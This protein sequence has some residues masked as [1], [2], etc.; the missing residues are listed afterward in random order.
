MSG[1]SRLLLQVGR[2][3]GLRRGQARGDGIVGRHA[4][5]VICA[6]DQ[7]SCGRKL[8]AFL[9]VVRSSLDFLMRSRTSRGQDA[10]QLGRRSAAS[11]RATG[12]GA[13]LRFP[14]VPRRPK[15]NPMPPP[16]DPDLSVRSAR[17]ELFAQM[18]AGS[19]IETILPCPIRPRREQH[20][21]RAFSRNQW[22]STPRSSDQNDPRG[23]ILLGGSGTQAGGLNPPCCQSWQPSI[24]HPRSRPLRP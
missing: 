22:C 17:P 2:R 15:V 5:P 6:A 21:R 12:I 24:I 18:T 1:N 4:D 20:L 3:R 8:I 16:V 23:K 14:R 10:A 13:F 11:S 9:H 19:G 7:R